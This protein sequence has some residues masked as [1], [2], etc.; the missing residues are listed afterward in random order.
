MLQLN[1]LLPATP[2]GARLAAAGVP[3][4]GALAAGVI[5]PETGE[6]MAF[7][8]ELH[9]LLMA[10]SPEQVDRL[11][12]LLQGGM[13]LPQAASAVL[14]GQP[15]GQA[16]PLPGSLPAGLPALPVEAPAAAAEAE[17]A[18]LEALARHPLA[19]A[20][21]A[22]M[23]GGQADL[24]AP[25]TPV[26]GTL[27][28]GA[29]APLLSGPLGSN[30]LAMGVPQRVGSPEWADAVNERVFWMAQGGQQFARL[31]LNPPN[32]GPLE[33]RLNLSQD[34]ASVSFIAGQ[35]AVREALEAALPRLRDMFDQQSLLLVRAE[36]RDPGNGGGQQA[37]DFERGG[38][39][40][41]G[42]SADT[43]LPASQSAAAAVQVSDRLVDL[44]A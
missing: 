39:S 2:D 16:A 11:Q 20:M 4:S 22:L 25:L 31:Q 40:G 18:G 14:A 35:A 24:R 33:V 36:V 1:L 19:A 23:E 13:S 21:E 27:P 30:L 6:P 44:F 28:Q 26:S 17:P 41:G 29:L 12:G 10:L 8:A 3:A 5:D 38:G 37:G 7:A 15:G 34:Q 32:L 43:A 42:G 9:A